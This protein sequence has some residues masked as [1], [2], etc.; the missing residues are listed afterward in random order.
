ML[1]CCWHERRARQPQLHGALVPEGGSRC[2]VRM[3]PGP[4][5]PGNAA[6]P[7]L[8]TCSSKLTAAICLT[9][10][11]IYWPVL[12]ILQSQGHRL[13]RRNIVYFPPKSLLRGSDDP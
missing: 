10:L 12:G 5:I 11:G 2:W 3:S 7:A 9:P 8:A 4:V 6:T 13:V 1:A